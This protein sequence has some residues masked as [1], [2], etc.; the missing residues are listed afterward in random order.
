MTTG[1]N[2][3]P[4]IPLESLATCHLKRVNVDAVPRRMRTESRRGFT[5][6][7]IMIS[8]AI[9]GILASIAIPNFTRYQLHVK[10]TEARTLAVG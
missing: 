9:V 7:E 6:I 1:L 3:P 4:S 2:P 8:V 10:T 5:L